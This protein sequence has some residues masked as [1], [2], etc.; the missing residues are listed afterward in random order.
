MIHN[1]LKF[2]SLLL[3]PCGWGVEAWIGVWVSYGKL[4]CLAT[5]M[6]FGRTKQICLWM[7]IY[8]YIYTRM[9]IYVCFTQPLHHDQDATQGYSLLERRATGLNS[10]FS[11]TRLVALS[12]LKNPACYIII[13]N[14]REKEEMDSC[15]SQGQ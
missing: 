3:F 9:Y 15:L 10:E 4:V 8:T 11:S 13:H 12:R 14:W 2:T 1:R 7:S 5:L 6:S